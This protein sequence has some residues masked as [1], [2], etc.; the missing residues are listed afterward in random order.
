M[1][2]LITIQKK[3]RLIEIYAIDEV[4]ASGTYRHYAMVMSQLDKLPEK[5]DAQSLAELM[6]QNEPICELCS[7]HGVVE[8]DLLEIVR[9]RLKGFQSGKLPTEENAQALIHVE[10]AL[11]W[12]KSQSRRQN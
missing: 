12:L 7:T 6:F 2:K 8:T 9:D 1:K 5:R 11:M 4:G 3:E 10:E